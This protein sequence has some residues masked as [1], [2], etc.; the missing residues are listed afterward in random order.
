MINAVAG[1]D[2]NIA[3]DSVS[4][5]GVTGDSG[6]DSASGYGIAVAGTNVLPYNAANSITRVKIT[7]CTV[8]KCRNGIHVE[9]VNKPSLSG[10]TVQDVN[11]SYYINSNESYGIIVYG[12]FDADI[13][14]ND[15]QDVTGDG[16]Y[17][18]GIGLRGGFYGGS[19][20]QP[21]YNGRVTDNNLR[22]ASFIVEQQVR[23]AASGSVPA[24][25]LTLGSV[26]LFDGN[27][28]NN[29]V[30]AIYGVSTVKARN[31][32]LVG[33][34]SVGPLTVASYTRAANVATLSGVLPVSTIQDVGVYVGSII[35][36][37]GVGAGFDSQFA[38]VTAVAY[39]AGNWSVSYSNAGA[40]VGTTAGTGNVY[41]L[42]RT[43]LFNGSDTITGNASFNAFFRFN[44]SLENNQSSNLYGQSS[45][46]LTNVSTGT[47]YAA[48]VRVSGTG[49][50]F[51]VQTS[52][53]PATVSNRVL[54]TTAA[55]NPTGLEF[56]VGDEF[57]NT[58]GGVAVRQFCTSPGYVS[59]GATSYTIVS[60]TAGTIKRTAGTSWLSTTPPWSYGQLITVTNGGNSIVGLLQKVE[61][62]A[63]DEVI[64]LVDPALGT[65]L[66]L[67][68]VGGPGTLSPYATAAFSTF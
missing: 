25:D 42:I 15:V 47:R 43:L 44:L 22:N 41:H 19:Y 60:S 1:R 40:N 48:N 27:T 34:L 58:V 21:S 7:N 12:S 56:V 18:W 49:N 33:P 2:K 46:S 26:L 57:V 5:D 66:D 65:A 30:A 45:F 68:S 24:V 59:P 52:Y 4:V 55:G 10:N 8:T 36:I 9:Y 3:I 20:Q 62:V 39:A 14:S 53:L 32:T 54:Y 37:A 13:F 29:G 11:V 61:L 17:A 35:K 23:S 67:S 51:A 31:N 64:T 16:I 50:N 28:T 6:G 63:A 38:T